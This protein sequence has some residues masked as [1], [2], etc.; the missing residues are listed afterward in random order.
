MIRMKGTAF[1][2]NAK[3]L[4]LLFI[5]A[6]TVISG[7]TGIGPGTTG[8]GQG[9]AVDIFRP[10]L[11]Q[12]TPIESEEPVSFH[13]EVINR[14]NY[15][16]APAVAEL[17]GI[18]TA[19]WS[20]YGDVYR[21]LGLLLAPDPESQTEGGRGRADWD[22]VTPTLPRNQRMTYEP[23][24]RV[25]YYYETRV[26]KP[27]W[28]VTS[29]ELRRI[30]DGAGTLD[31]EPTTTWAGPLTV[32][33]DTG[34]FVKARDWRESKFQLQIRID[35]TGGGQIFGRD[36][37]VAVEVIW[38]DGVIPVGDCPRQIEFGTGIYNNLPPF[39]STPAFGRF[40]R[41]WNGQY[42]DITCEFQVTNPPT[43]KVKKN[44]DVKLGYIYY[45]DA[46][47]QIT[48]KGFEEFV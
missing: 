5:A 45:V 2:R 25:Y 26:R 4:L 30:V 36:Y 44:F 18:D 42:T 12:T 11:G 15:N 13:L 21:D 16:N 20:I 9:I 23:I 37:P 6:V 40:V 24:A 3:F 46:A 38:P 7:C 34:Q 32:T 19:E 31:S 48:V 33:V 22:A 47:T 8:G 14:G 28:F 39:L 41:V 35:N 43:N 29:E 1:G 10:T 17:T 27:V